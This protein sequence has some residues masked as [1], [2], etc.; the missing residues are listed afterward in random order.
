LADG[1]ATRFRECFRRHFEI[2]QAA[3]GFLEAVKA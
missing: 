3:R 2:T 1:D